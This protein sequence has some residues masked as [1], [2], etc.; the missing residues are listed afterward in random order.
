VVVVDVGLGDPFREKDLGDV[1]SYS[2]P[3][4]LLY[5][6]AVMLRP[7]GLKHGT[8]TKMT[9]SSILAVS[10]SSLLRRSWAS[11]GDIW[12]PPIS[13]AW[14]LMDWQTTTFALDRRSLTSS[15]VRPRGSLILRLISLR[16]SRFARFSGDEMTTSRKGTPS[17]LGPM[18]LTFILSLCC[19]SR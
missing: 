6:S 5:Q 7:S 13:E 12:V 18:S 16:L 15:S 8:I 17:V 3:S 14:R 11:S 1:P 19:W 10:S 2:V 9:F 4:V